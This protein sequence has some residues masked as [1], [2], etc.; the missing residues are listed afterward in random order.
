[1]QG[2]RK[3]VVAISLSP[4][5]KSGR[6]MWMYS[7]EDFS[8]ESFEDSVQSAENNKKLKNNGQD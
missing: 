1:M 5:Q 2:L 6:K 3:K 8:S 7:F 4:G